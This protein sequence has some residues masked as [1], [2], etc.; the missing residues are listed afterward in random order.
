MSNIFKYKALL[1]IITCISISGCITD[2]ILWFVNKDKNYE[3]INKVF[4]KYVD[5]FPSSEEA[6]SLNT[7]WS[8]SS[9]DEYNIKAVFKFK[10]KSLFHQINEEIKSNSVIKYKADEECL[11]VLNRFTTNSNY[12]YPSNSEV[13]DS[14]INLECYENLYPIPNFSNFDDYQTNKTQ[15]KLSS[16]F[17]IYVLDSKLGKFL[18]KSD[19]T[20]GKYMPKKWR[21]GLSRGVALSEKRE[22]AIYWI[23]IW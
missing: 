18:P 10:D 1:F 8:L 22:I 5:F 17:V 4:N 13:I 7:T 16:D 6:Y 2:N 11:L 9:E 12:G 15:C 20:K 19:I 3:R 14:L 21:N 23:I